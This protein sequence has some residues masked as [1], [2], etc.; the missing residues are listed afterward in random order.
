MFYNNLTNGSE[1]FSDAT[2]KSGCVSLPLMGMVLCQ[3]S[4]F[5]WNSLKSYKVNTKEFK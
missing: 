2:T 4:T 3:H 5:F 1:N